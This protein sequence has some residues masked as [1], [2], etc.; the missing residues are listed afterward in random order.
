MAKKAVMIIAS[1]GFRDEEFKVPHLVLEDNG[2]KVTIASSSL[3]TARGILGSRVNPDLL[4]GDIKVK[5]YDVIIFVGGA[6]SQEYWDEPIAHN[7]V[8]E[9]VKQNKVLAAICIAPIILA[10]AGELKGKKA[11]V[12]SSE[13]KRLKTQGAVYVAESVAVDGKIITANGPTSASLFADK[14]LEALGR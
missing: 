9:A 2:V 14:I 10:N 13:I 1:N 11:T 12:W 3:S 5:D 6:G 4:I 8:K 7:I